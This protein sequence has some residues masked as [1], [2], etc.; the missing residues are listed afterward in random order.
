MATSEFESSNDPILIL[1]ILNM[2]CL[3][4]TIVHGAIATKSDPTDIAIY[5]QRHFD[6]MDAPDQKQEYI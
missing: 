4:G 3:L 2:I 5:Y 6:A 1:F